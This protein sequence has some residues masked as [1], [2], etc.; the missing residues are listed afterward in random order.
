MGTAD[1]EALVAAAASGRECDQAVAK[2]RL[3]RLAI[4]HMRTVVH[5]MLR[6][7]PAVSRWEQT[8]DVLQGAVMRFARALEVVTPRDGDHLIR[9]MALQ[10]RRELLDLARKYSSD[11][12]FARHLD[13]NAIA[14]R[15]NAMQVEV[16][17][18]S[19][20]SCDDALVSWA[21]FHAAADALD[22]P[23]RELFRLVWYL[24][25]TQE[26]AAKMLGCSVRTVARR[27]EATK[28]HLLHR[29]RGELP[30]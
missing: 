23:E 22:N 18:A 4:D 15:S 10:V 14:N 17:A 5:R 6:G 8:D 21:E 16:A 19:D 11:G 3:V 1:F 30:T 9:L 20:P 28:R 24:G 27:W 26:Q 12:S 2:D 25:L 29:L 7:F 13:T